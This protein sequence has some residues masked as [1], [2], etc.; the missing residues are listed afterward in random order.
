MI[1]PTRI[2]D[3]LTALNQVL[4]MG[5]LA[6]RRVLYEVED[7]LREAAEHE[8]RAG[9]AGEEAE[10]RAIERF[11][12]PS[13]IAQAFREVEKERTPQRGYALVWLSVSAASVGA[14]LASLGTQPGPAVVMGSYAEPIPMQAVVLESTPP[15]PAVVRPTLAPAP[16]HARRVHKHATATPAAP[17]AADPAAPPELAEEPLEA[18][19]QTT[20]DP[21]AAPA[22]P[23]AQPAA[24]PARASPPSS[25]PAAPASA[26]SLAQA[27]KPLG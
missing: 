15:A 6:R 25:K 3:Y 11:G 4:A 5:P 9:L 7:H 18:V 1:S 23:V 26:R 2:A 27:P 20:P 16:R 17:A 10:R 21:P 22:A 13:C 24:E 8:Q 14:L 12:T 19:T